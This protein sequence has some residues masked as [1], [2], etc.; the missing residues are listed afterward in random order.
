MVWKHTSATLI[1]FYTLLWIPSVTTWS[2]L[3]T[4]TQLWKSSFSFTYWK[5]VYGFIFLII[6]SRECFNLIDVEGLDE[7]NGGCCIWLI[8]SIGTLTIYLDLWGHILK[9]KC[10]RTSCNL[11]SFIP[12]ISFFSKN[13]I[14][15]KIPTVCLHSNVSVLPWL[16]YAFTTVCHS[17]PYFSLLYHA[18]ARLYYT[19]LY[20]CY[21]KLL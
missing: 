16:W 21:G 13:V 4:A 11:T 8:K 17:L 10:N 9:Y 2:V 3:G 5:Q 14:C 6:I 1:A 15:F 18:F 7:I 12:C 20:F 19:L